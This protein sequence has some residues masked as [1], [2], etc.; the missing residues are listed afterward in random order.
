MAVR[1]LNHQPP[2]RH[3]LSRYAANELIKLCALRGG[4]ETLAQV[5]HPTSRHRMEHVTDPLI[6]SSVF[7]TSCR[8]KHNSLAPKFRDYYREAIRLI[9][10]FSAILRRWSRRRH[11]IRPR[12]LFPTWHRAVM[13]MPLISRASRREKQIPG[14]CQKIP[15]F[16]Q[17]W[18]SPALY[19]SYLY[20]VRRTFE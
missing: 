16:D 20:W 10:R 4:H 17:D 19:S 15:A 6:R 9:K 5:F 8:E 3:V 1:Q 7:L 14:S 12:Y 2:C 11:Q 13:D 18:D